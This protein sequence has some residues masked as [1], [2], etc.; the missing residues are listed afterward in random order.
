MEGSAGTVVGLERYIRLEVGGVLRYQSESTAEILEDTLALTHDDCFREK[1][2][3]TR[4][5]RKEWL[6]ISQSKESG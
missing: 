3:K 6:I 5:I 2:R 4:I 1:T